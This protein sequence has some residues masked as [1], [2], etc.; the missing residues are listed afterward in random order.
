MATRPRPSRGFRRAGVAPRGNG[1][2]AMPVVSLGLVGA[3]VGAWYGSHACLT[4]SRRA[5]VVVSAAVGSVTRCTSSFGVSVTN[6][7]TVDSSGLGTRR[8]VR[9]S[10]NIGTTSTAIAGFAVI[11]PWLTNKGSIGVS[12]RC[13]SAR[14]LGLGKAR[15]G[16][17]TSARMAVP[18][19]ARNGL[20]LQGPRTLGFMGSNFMASSRMAAS[21]RRAD[22][23]RGL[24]GFVVDV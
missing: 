5:T 3:R 18:T 15:G 9:G 7:G 14:P 11:R 16:V 20:R 13:G 10:A 12:G 21:L 24:A 17:P 6:F 8:V 1:A 22:G 19:I 23:T 4:F 2:A